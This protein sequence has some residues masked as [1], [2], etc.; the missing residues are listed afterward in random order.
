M[1]LKWSQTLPNLF[2][3][4]TKWC[5]RSNVI[6]TKWCDRNT[7]MWSKWC[8]RNK[9]M[10]SK[11]CARSHGHHD[12]LCIGNPLLR[13][14]DLCAD[15]SRRYAGRLPSIQQFIWKIHMKNTYACFVYIA[16]NLRVSEANEVPI[17]SHIWVGL[18]TLNRL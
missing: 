3:K 12:A 5:D 17:S 16:C 9:V 10:W 18:S 11:W 13:I 7:V 6:E 4:R 15:M 14:S 1:V 2:M 8:D